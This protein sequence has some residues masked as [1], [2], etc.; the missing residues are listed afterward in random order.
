MIL[1]AIG[2]G[3]LRPRPSAGIKPGQGMTQ[4]VSIA[5]YDKWIW[6]AAGILSAATERKICKYNADWDYRYNS[7]V[8]IVTTRDGNNLEDF[9]WDQ[10]ADMGMGEGDALLAISARDENWFVA[11]GEDFSSILTNRVVSELEDVLSGGLNDKTVLAFYAALD[12]VYQENFGM[13][14]EQGGASYDSN[15]VS[16]DPTRQIN[17]VEGIVVIVSV[18]FVI[19]VVL[20]IIDR[21]RYNDYRRQY[22]GMA[23]PPYAFRPIFF[24]HGPRYG[25]YRRRWHRPPPRHHNPGYGGGPRPGGYGGPGSS[26]FSRPN[27]GSSSGFGGLGNFGPRGGGTFGGRPSGSSHSGGFG[28]SFGSSSRGGGLSGSTRSGGRGGGFS[29]GSRGGGFGGRR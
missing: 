6:D 2:I 20:N 17:Q 22:Y 27:V 18:L 7:V 9:A 21:S 1:I 23:A 25:W 15:H 19:I 3:Q 29:G 16:H 8:G 11:P 5:E 28:G 24:W 10:G 14:N 26:N 13:G 4:T 12:K